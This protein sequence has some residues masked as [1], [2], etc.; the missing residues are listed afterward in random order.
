M[1]ATGGRLGGV[2]RW[3]WG[4]RQRFARFGVVGVSGV[5]IN[6][7]AIWACQEHLY[8]GIA[9][10]SLRLALAMAT[11]IALGMTNNFHW[12]RTWTWKDRSRAQ[13]LPLLH[14]YGQYAAANWVGILLQYT[15]TYTLKSHMPLLLANAVSIGFACVVNFALNDLWTYRHVRTEGIDPEEAQ[16]HDARVVVPLMISGVILA[17]CTYLHGLGALQILRNGDELVYMQITRTTAEAGHWLPLQSGMQDMR[18]T[19][20][21]LLFWQGLLSTDWGAWWS[22]VALRWPSVVW[23]MLTALA[24]GLVTWKVSGRNAFRG[25]LAALFYLAFFS[26][27][28]YGRPFLTNA[29]ETFWVSG[30]FLAMLWWQP[31][32][33]A[34]RA[35]FPTLI[36]AL[37]GMAL[38]TKSFAQLLPMGLGL[39]VWHLMERRWSVGAFMRQAV[40]GLV[41]VAVLSLGMFSLWFALDPDPAAVWREF[42][43]G[44][45]VG[46]MGSGGV[47]AW[48]VGL[49]W[50]GSSV[51]TLAGSWLVNAGLLAFPLFGVSVECWRH[52]RSLTPQERLLWAWV[53]VFFVVF[54]LPSQRSGRYLLEAM[55]A[56][57]AIMALRWHHVGRNAFMLT[58]GA[59]VV[60]AACTAWVSLQLC[61]DIG[62]GAL[63]WWHWLLCISVVI[64]GVFGLVS[65][66]WTVL[67]AAPVSLG[68]FLCISSF[69][70]VFNAPLGTFDA[71]AVQAARGRTV[72]VP[73]SFR[74]TAELERFLL[75]GAIVRGFP[76]HGQPPEGEVK[77]DDLMVKSLGLDGAAPAGALGSHIA[78]T[79]RHTG[80]QIWRMATGEVQRHLFRREWLVPVRPAP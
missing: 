49:L 33:F 70:A 69:L 16:L 34:S 5:A 37:A 30:A 78:I 40:P 36:G 10:E 58:H 41:W 62:F 68:V 18:N 57:A 23:T 67:L 15:L 61:L 42:V 32:S 46:K 39:A 72:W 26:T 71:A 1:S 79:S 24:T 20:P 75:P 56:V 13:E 17:L 12:N 4:Q 55:P 6:M 25:T 9:N 80:E 44:E 38:L 43:L 50:S 65:R 73:E 29:P 7:A 22:P 59:A 64:A 11:G 76:E 63:E 2:L 60:V 3:A 52:R 74:S 35:V 45:N 14:Q 47:G 31:R 54:C 77:P 19:K 28:R 66:G 48:L 51:W 53:L 21:P 27:Y 8:A